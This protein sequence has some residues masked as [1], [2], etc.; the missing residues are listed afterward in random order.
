M[1]QEESV[2]DVADNT[3]A[4]KVKCFRVLG[5]TKRRYA[6]VGDIIIGSVKEAAPKGAVKKGDKVKAVI[7]RT[8]KEIKRND[9]SILKFY[10]N[11]CVIL[12]DKKNPRGTRIFGS[13]AREIREKFLKICSLAPEVI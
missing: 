3:G 12:D 5:G 2:L 6:Y 9:G 13:V 8:K 10:D 4:K 11:S 1:I 7:V